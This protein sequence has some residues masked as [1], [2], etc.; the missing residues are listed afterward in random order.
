METAEAALAVTDLDVLD[1]LGVEV[2]RE[3]CRKRDW[4]AKHFGGAPTGGDFIPKTVG[5]ML[6]AAQQ[7][8]A[9]QRAWKASDS[10]RFNLNLIEAAAKLKLALPMI[11]KLQEDFALGRI[12][13]P[14]DAVTGADAVA[15]L[16]SD[17]LDAVATAHAVAKEIEQAAL[18]S[19]A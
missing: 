2:R 7:R 15:S 3:Q 4:E 18:K 17:A 19:L 12:D 8:V 16:L 10:G 13:S 1:A 5:E 11:D 14:D 6:T 9:M